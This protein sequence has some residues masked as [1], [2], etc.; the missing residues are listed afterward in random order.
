MIINNA[1]IKD[2]NTHVDC[3]ASGGVDVGYRMATNL[4]LIFN[5]NAIFA[6]ILQTNNTVDTSRSSTCATASHR[7]R[8]SSQGLQ[9]KNKPT[10]TWSVAQ[11]PSSDREMAKRGSLL[12]PRSHNGKTRVLEPHDSYLAERV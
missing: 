11:G 7:I 2:A 4:F 6:F 3:R 10:I 8:V 1:V 9:A 12:L 5:H